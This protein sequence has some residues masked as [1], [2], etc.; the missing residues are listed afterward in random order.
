[1]LEDTIS[2]ANDLVMDNPQKVQYKD[3]ND[4]VH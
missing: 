4:M 1:M 2:S 3:N